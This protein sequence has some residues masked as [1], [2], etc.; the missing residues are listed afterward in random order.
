[1]FISKLS[2]EL[3]RGTLNT[4]LESTFECLLSVIIENVTITHPETDASVGG[5]DDFDTECT[6]SVLIDE[7]KTN[8]RL[9]DLTSR[10][11]GAALGSARHECCTS[12]S[13]SDRDQQ[14][15]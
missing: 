6:T 10:M 4:E 1:M 3:K 14:S 9:L 13:A 5:I 2:T 8:N 12:S 7:E 11:V 15:V